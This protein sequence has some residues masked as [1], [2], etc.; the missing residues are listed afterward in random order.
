MSSPKMVSV[1]IH[2]IS[3]NNTVLSLFQGYPVNGIYAENREL[4]ATNIPTSIIFSL[5]KYS[6]GLADALMCLKT[7]DLIHIESKNLGDTFEFYAETK[8]SPEDGSFQILDNK[9]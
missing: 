6:K 8:D 5:S 1:L 4:D 7:I 3:I 9:S 2:K